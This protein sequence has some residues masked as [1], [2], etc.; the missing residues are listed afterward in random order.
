M[1]SEEPIAII[2]IG[3]RAAEGDNTHDLRQ[4][5]FTGARAAHSREAIEVTPDGP[6]VPSADLQHSLAREALVLEAAS[7]AVASLSLPH[8]R[9]MVL[10]GAGCDPEVASRLSARLDLAGPS[11]TVSAEEAS[12]VVALDHAA[13]A[14]HGGDADAAIVGAVDLSHE[15]VRQAAP[16]AHGRAR[17]A[18]DVAVVLVLKRLG[19]ARRDGD[20]VIALLDEKVNEETVDPADL[21]VG[22]GGF[23]TAELFGTRHVAKGLLNVAAAALALRHRAMPRVGSPADPAFD[24][25]RAE[26]V[27]APPDAPP[28]R[29]WLRAAESAP[30]VAE[31]PPRL[32]VYSGADQAGALASLAAGHESPGG[33]ARLVIL[34]AD[35]PEL[36]A[37]AGA[38]RAW[39]ARGG[40][41]PRGV[42][43]RAAPLCGEVGFVFA[44]GMAAYAGMGREVLLAFPHLVEQVETS[45]GSLRNIVGWAFSGPDSEPGQVLDQIGATMLLSRVHTAITRD[46]LSITPRAALG[47]SAG[48]PNALVSL[49]AWTDVKSMARQTSASGLFTREVAGEFAAIRR[50]WARRGI[51][52]T[53]WVNYLVGSTPGQVREALSGERAVH[54]IAIN[55]PDSCVIG[56]EA[57]ACK[58]VLAR[59]AT[60]Y[61]LRIPYRLAVHVPELKEV[62]QEWWQLHHQPTTAPPGVR[63]YSCATTEPYI[64]TTESAADALT[65]QAIGTMNFAGVVTRAW[66]DGVRVFIE[67][68]PK[69]LCTSWIRQT[70]AD[71]EHLA[72]HLDASGGRGVQHLTQVIAELVAAGV[73]VSADVLLDHLAAAWPSPTDPPHTMSAPVPPSPARLPEIAPVSETMLR[74]PKL[75]PVLAVYDE[76]APVATASVTAGPAAGLTAARAATPGPLAAALSAAGAQH[77]LAV[78][79]HREFVTRQGVAHTRFLEVR[80]NADATL[81]QM[82][83]ASPGTASPG[84]GTPGLPGPKFEGPARAAGGVADGAHRPHRGHRLRAGLH[85]DRNDPDR[86]RRA[87]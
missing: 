13:R 72:V 77:Q 26:V 29:V 5:L 76:T 52:G 66:D 24:T 7:E 48:E 34:A 31:R 43:F 85:G 6:H 32:H 39:L 10:V 33:P 1:Y 21:R 27:V 12:G 64:P 42:A 11:V 75:P 15:A 65:S 3:S 44:G 87:C 30:W 62:R 81:L 67:H 19:D 46:L 28:V 55:S 70:L 80:G 84:T 49:G 20:Q 4:V 51:E 40:P 41:P 14:L 79:A 35:G 8:E 58:Q 18:G 16:T 23:D 36:A 38:A 71:R 53:K 59:L 54:L 2:A 25:R 78:T 37:R 60:T 74:A 68:G 56:G 50:A 17:T 57:V 69:G 61:T 63:F 83:A 73:P 45:F 47:Y 22:D 9:T 86:D 82:I